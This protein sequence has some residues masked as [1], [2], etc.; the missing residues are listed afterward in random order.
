MGGGFGVW[1]HMTNK[2]H[3]K[4][5]ESL[6]M[7]KVKQEGQ[8]ILKPEQLLTHFKTQDV[9]GQQMYRIQL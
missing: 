3:N 7:G 1:N 2:E 6:V 4:A 5:V 8:G 9:F